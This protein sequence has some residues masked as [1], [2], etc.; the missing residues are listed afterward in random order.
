MT[1]QK[2]L[3]SIV[4]TSSFLLPVAA[5][6]CA[7]IWIFSNSPKDSSHWVGLAF[8]ALCTYL[9]AELNNSYMLI[10]VRTRMVATTFLVLWTCCGFLYPAQ[11]AHVGVLCM[12]LIYHAL[13]H[14]YQLTQTAGVTFF[15]F[16]LLGTASIFIQPLILLVPVLYVMLG[17]FRTLSF[18]S[19]LAG[20]LGCLLPFWLSISICFL[21][22][23]MDLIWNYVTN[24]SQ[25]VPFLYQAVTLPWGIAFGVLLVLVI[26]GMVNFLRNS[27]KDKI[28]TRTFFYVFLWMELI[29]LIL[30]LVL[31]HLFPEFYLLLVLNGCPLIAHFFTLTGNKFSNIFFKVTL[32]VLLLL[33]ICNLWMP[34]YSFS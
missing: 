33:L 13:F 30:M 14:C 10:R 18:K 25:W 9:M 4:T 22:D 8:C 26:P 2:G 16:L 12:I 24:Y 28:R 11:Y 5:V 31:P 7:L 23:R 27:Y 1:S 32:L 6:C 29:L 19:F 15:I 21:T 20:I 3:Q 17:Y 34:S